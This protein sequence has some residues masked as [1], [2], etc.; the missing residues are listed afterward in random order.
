MWTL[1]QEA[2]DK[3]LI[4][5][6]GDRDSGSDKYLTPCK[7]RTGTV[8]GMT[9][10]G[11][12]AS[13]LFDLDNDGDLDIVTSDFNAEP[14]IL[15]SNLAQKKPDLSWLEVRLV[16]TKSNRDGIGA[17]VVVKAGG[18]TWTQWMDGKSGYLSQ[19]SM[20]LYFGLAGAK[21]IDSVEVTSSGSTS[22]IE[23]RASCRLSGLRAV[24]NTRWPRR[25]SSTAS[26]RPMPVEQPVISTIF[27]SFR[28]IARV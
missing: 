16:G 25:A 17:R 27:G 26:A 23:L 20:P 22:S 28:S 24:A 1:T 10:L 3:L 4:T 9:T 13:V 12:R 5:L 6:G 8:R 7:G 2:F 14:Q 15:V 11:S 21:K 18:R 19:S